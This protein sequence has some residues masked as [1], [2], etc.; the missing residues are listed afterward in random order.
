MAVDNG[1]SWLF[2]A[3]SGMEYNEEI[4]NW[5]EQLLKIPNI[6]PQDRQIIEYTLE[7]AK[8]GNTYPSWSYYEVSCHYTTP[9]Y[10]Y[11]LGEVGRAFTNIV[12]FYR[13]RRVIDSIYTSAAETNTSDELLQELA[14]IMSE[15]GESSEYALDLRSRLYRWDY[16]DEIKRPLS[17]GIKLGVP[18]ID[19][20]TNGFQGGNI[21]TIGGFT[22]H[23]KSISCLSVLY[24]AAA[25]GKK[26]AYVSL[27]LPMNT[28]WLMME[29]RYMYET[30]GIHLNSQDLLHHKISG[31]RLE[32]IKKHEEQWH[33]DV[34]DNIIVVDESFFSKETFMD[35]ARLRSMWKMFDEVLGGLDLIVLDHVGQLNLMYLERGRGLGNDIIVKLRQS[36]LTYVNSAGEQ[37]VMV[38]AAQTNRQ[39]MMRA[40]RNGG[41]YD[42]TALSDLNEIERSS[43]YVCFIYTDEESS[44]SQ[45][46][47]M[48]LAKH[49]FGAPLPE[50]VVVS[51]LPGVLTIGETVEAMSLTD[52][53]GDMDGVD[54]GGGG[55]SADLNAILD[56]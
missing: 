5:L 18:E 38:F 32:Q 19:D 48:S 8:E 55:L 43:S 42:L 49:R 23:G 12:E 26:C 29:A 39:G 16:S 10:K 30:K 41:H 22:G 52:D 21:V 2:Y 47:K 46:C 6:E 54:F 25:K 44:Q 37:P 35:T 3:F 40:K 7:S 9:S 36:I 4:N 15:M 28:V 51:F 56:L 20:L 24:K 31:D 13:R 14:T 50:P 53:F 11:S 45:Q 1:F 33:R 34:R 27:E 17:S